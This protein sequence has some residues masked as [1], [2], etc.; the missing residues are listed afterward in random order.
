MRLMTNEFVVP[1]VHD[2]IGLR[3]GQSI[4]FVLK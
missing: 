2:E 3:V 1:S 4:G